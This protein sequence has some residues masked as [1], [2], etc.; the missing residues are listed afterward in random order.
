MFKS[1]FYKCEKC[2]SIMQV[3]S[4][5]DNEMCCCGKKSSELVCNSTGANTKVHI[6]IVEVNGSSV[7]VLVG[8]NPHPMTSEHLIEWISLKT[9]KGFYSRK[10]CAN[11]APNT[12]F[13]LTNEKVISIYAYCNLHGLWE[14][15]L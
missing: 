11:E 5:C 6:P 2:N 3:L 4:S 13:A 15:D 12:T 14:T 1:K 7:K 10:I 9:D 8:E